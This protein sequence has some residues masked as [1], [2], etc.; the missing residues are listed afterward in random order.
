MHAEQ[1]LHPLVSR[2][3]SRTDR[4]QGGVDTAAMLGGRVHRAVEE[5]A[6][7]IVCS[8]PIVPKAPH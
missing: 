2:A 1:R 6:G 4:I 8:L 7:R 5:L 3:L